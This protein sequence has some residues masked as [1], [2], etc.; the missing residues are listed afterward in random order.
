M[1]EV[2]FQRCAAA[3]HALAEEVR[4]Q[5]A[6]VVAVQSAPWRSTAADRFR[7]VLGREAAAGRRCAE[8]L[9]EAARAVAAHARAVGTAALG[10]AALGTVP[11]SSC[12]FH[13]LRDLRGVG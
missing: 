12:R 2:Q 6:R 7:A 13:A 11:G 9:D 5:A 8:A 4:G 10:T 3:L 1:D